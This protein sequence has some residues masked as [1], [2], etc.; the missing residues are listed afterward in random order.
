[1]Y[2][3]RIRCMQCIIVFLLVLVPAI[4]H[5]ATIKV[6]NTNLAGPGSLSEAVHITSRDGDTIVFDIPLPN[7]IYVWGFQIHK[8]LT[9]KGG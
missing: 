4:S 3:F 6:T 9:I 2:N 5:S 7:T 8:N 1:M